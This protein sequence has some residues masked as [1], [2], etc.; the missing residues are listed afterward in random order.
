MFSICEM[1]LLVAVVMGCPAVGHQEVE[2]GWVVG[3]LR[4]SPA[5]HQGAAVHMLNLH[6]DGST[7]AYWEE[8]WKKK[9]G[10]KE[11]MYRKRND[12][13]EQRWKDGDENKDKREDEIKIA[14]EGGRNEEKEGRE[15]VADE[16]KE[17]ARRLEEEVRIGASEEKRS[18]VEIKNKRMDRTW[19]K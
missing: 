15:R 12:V 18:K 16:C 10:K 3:D 9:G 5:D 17:Q 14:G 13:E 19:I 8:G 2:D 6:V 4:T 7:A 11:E 1:R